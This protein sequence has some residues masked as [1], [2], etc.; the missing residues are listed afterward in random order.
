MTGAVGAN[1]A[2]HRRR[3]VIPKEVMECVEGERQ[4]ARGAR[5]RRL[6]TDS[7]LVVEAV[8]QI[9]LVAPFLERVFESIVEV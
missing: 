8:L 6:F 3:G 4:L 2:K 5:L 9:K 1:A 7:V